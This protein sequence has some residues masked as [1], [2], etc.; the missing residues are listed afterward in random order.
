MPKTT[1][2]SL[3]NKKKKGASHFSSEAVV[4]NTRFKL[5]LLLTKSYRADAPRGN[6]VSSANCMEIDLDDETLMDETNRFIIY[7]IGNFLLT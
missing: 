2:I 7:T 6:Y 1:K 4:L 5:D 3:K